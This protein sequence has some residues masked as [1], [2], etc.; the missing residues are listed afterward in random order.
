MAT[1]VDVRYFA[2]FGTCDASDW[3]D[4]I[5]VLEGEAEKAYLEA[6]KL[7]LPFDDYPILREALEEAYSEIEEE[8]TDNHI[9]LGDEFALEC[10]GQNRVDPDEINELVAER[11]PYTLEFFDLEDMTDEELDAWD[12]NNLDDLPE[13]CEFKEDFVPSSPFDNGWDLCVEYAENPEEIE[14]EEDEAGETLKELFQRSDGDFNEVEDF[15]DRCSDLCDGFD[16]GELAVTVAGEM[17][18]V[19]EY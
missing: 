15:I 8:E 10:T 4:W 7:R 5:I 12:A 3:L 19:F 17:G 18:I 14:L 13:V 2:D 6:M 9:S 11:D 1:Y 16:L